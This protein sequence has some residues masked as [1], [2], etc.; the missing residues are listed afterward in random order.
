MNGTPIAFMHGCAHI[1]H[2]PVH[3]DSQDT[4]T[5]GVSRMDFL[6][7]LWNIILG[8]GGKVRHQHEYQNSN[9]WDY[10]YDGR[11]KPEDEDY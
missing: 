6:Y 7:D 9:K 4:T 10:S 1:A 11:Y 8:A 3:Q 5:E 2:G